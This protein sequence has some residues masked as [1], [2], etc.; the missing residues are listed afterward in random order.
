M[1]SRR[2]S[3]MQLIAVMGLSLACIAALARGGLAIVT[4]FGRSM[5]PTYQNGDRLLALR[6]G[7]R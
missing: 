3:M 7:K 2:Q 6:R 5:E 4:V 1:P